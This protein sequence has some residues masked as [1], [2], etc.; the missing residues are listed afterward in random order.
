M[1]LFESD[2][3]MEPTMHAKEKSTFFTTH[4]PPLLGLILSRF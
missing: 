4:A 1:S 2:F 3:V